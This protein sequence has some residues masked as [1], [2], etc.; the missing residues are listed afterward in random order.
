LRTTAQTITTMV[1]RPQTSFQS[2]TRLS[3][4]IAGAARPAV[5]GVS[6]HTGGLV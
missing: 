5:A 1:T 4:L 2:I 6:S 3:F